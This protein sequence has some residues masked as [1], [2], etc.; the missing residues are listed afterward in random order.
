V[1]AL[2]A[3][4]SFSSLYNLFFFIIHSLLQRLPRTAPLQRLQKERKPLLA[5][6]RPR[7]HEDHQHPRLHR[8]QGGRRDLR[9]ARR[10]ARAHRQ[11]AKSKKDTTSVYKAPTAR[12]RTSTMTVAAAAAAAAAADE[13]N[14]S[15]PAALEPSTLPARTFR[16]TTS[17]S[18]G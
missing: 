17:L 16:T 12:H 15:A 18:S 14:Q 3:T 5:S 2:S 10:L 6:A 11:P 8:H 9:E 4:K 7:A 1:C 13:T